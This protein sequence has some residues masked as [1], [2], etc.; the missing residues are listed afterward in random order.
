M[1]FYFPSLLLLWGI[2]ITTCTRAQLIC[3]HLK[4]TSSSQAVF[5]KYLDKVFAKT[6]SLNKKLNSQATKGLQQLQNLEEILKN[7][8]FKK[9]SIKAK[10]VFGDAHEQYKQLEKRLAGSTSLQQFIP[11]LDTLITSLKF[12]QQNSQLL[13]ST[14]ESQQKLK[15]AIAK[16]TD[17][18]RQLQKAVE[19][20][21]YSE[22]RSRYLKNLLENLGFSKDLN[23]LNKQV[24]YYK[25]QLDEYKSLLKDHKKFERKALELLSR[26][27][28]FNDFMRMNSQLASLFRMPA[29]SDDPVAMASLTG[30]QTREQV[31]ALLQNQIDIGGPSA[32]HQLQQN[33]QQAQSKLHELKEKLNGL[34]NASSN[35]ELPNGFIPNTQK[36]K[37]FRKRLELGTNIHSQKAKGY[38][39]VTSDIG[40]SL[41]YKLN[42]KSII[43]IGTSYKIGWGQSIRHIKI[44]YQGVG[45]RSFV[46]WKIKGS[47]WLSGG[48]ELNYRS[49]FENV[50]ELKRLSAWQQSGLLGMSKLV[51][52]K[53]KFFK[54]TKLQLLWD[55][56]SYRQVPETQPLIFRVGY[57]LN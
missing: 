57:N 32:Q 6:T 11:S 28:L 16:V 37:S 1:N 33:L 48:Y 18:E 2:T 40:I 36:A 46:D 51:S 7:K 3:L 50:D 30:L 24:Y 14:K 10:A 38:F 56:L 21:K 52:L 35:D 8:L 17:L 5:S 12:L 41:G 25:G 19:I 22:E 53:T 47:F 44:S 54:K 49:E 15:D 26:T 23:R 39:P 55:F 27:K 42:D 45:L 43:G 9:D 29:E 31:T 34:G 4:D 20:K 13:P